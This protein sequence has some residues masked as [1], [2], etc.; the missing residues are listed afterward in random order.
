MNNSIFFIPIDGNVPTH[1]DDTTIYPYN[2]VGMLSFNI[3]GNAYIGTATL[4]RF[5][6]EKESDLLLTCA[7][8]LYDIAEGEA[9]DVMFTPGFNDPQQ[10]YEPISAKAFRYPNGFKQVAVSLLTKPE[11]ATVEQLKEHAR[12][13]YALIK[14][15]KPIEIQDIF[16]FAVVPDQHLTD[17]AVK[18]AGY[19]YYDQEMAHAV[20]KIAEYEEDRIYHNMSTRAGASGSAIVDSAASRIIGIHTHGDSA[21]KLNY[22]VRITDVVYDNL[23]QWRDEMNND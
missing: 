12:Y 3:A 16:K 6:K 10:P 9:S 17:L 1:I 22:G 14:L 2:L 15:A 23:R 4:I 11:E 13:D 8:N 7:H 19:G 20:G 5:G 21:K 18:M